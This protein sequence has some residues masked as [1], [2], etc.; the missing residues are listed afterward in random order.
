M[1]RGYYRML[2]NTGRGIKSNYWNDIAGFP[3]Q[4]EP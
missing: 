2:Q 3:G 4:V 1:T